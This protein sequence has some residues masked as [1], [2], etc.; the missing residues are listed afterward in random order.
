[1]KVLVTG[2]LGFIG[3]HTVVELLNEG[4]EVVVIDNLSN[5]SI[6][7]I[8]KIKKITGKDI[9]FYEEDVCNIEA[10]EKIFTENQIDAVIHFAGFKA[11]GESVAKPIMYYENNLIS[12]L[13]LCEVM[14]KYNCKKLIFS[15]SATVYGDPEKLP[16]TEDCKVGG[17]TNPYGTSKLMIEQIL[18]D[19]VVSDSEFTPIVLR[20]FNPIGAHKSTLLGEDPNGIPNNLLPYINKVA[21]GELPYLNVYGNDYPTVDGTGV[22][23]YIYVLDLANGHVLALNKLKTNPGYVIYNLGTGEGT[24]VLEMVDAYQKATGIHIPIEIKPRR[25]G[26]V[27][28]NYANCDKAFKE[29]GFKA[30]YNVYDACLDGY[31]F[32][33]AEKNRKS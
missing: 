19:I 7:V 29:L 16:L 31:K 12:T 27:A 1:M 10:L 4:Y 11:V 28:E 17:T 21:V 8:D 25:D 32:Q 3:S 14:Q 20:Y 23:D 18:K 5:A 9:I 30:K 22:R 26:D 6:D 33:L 13:H 24:S 15:S 2:G